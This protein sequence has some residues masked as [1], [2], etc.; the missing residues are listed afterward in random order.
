M[1]SILDGCRP[2]YRRIHWTF[3]E[4]V[5]SFLKSPKTPLFDIDACSKTTNLFFKCCAPSFESYRLGHKIW[6]Y[7]ELVTV[8]EI[9]FCLFNVSNNCKPYNLDAHHSAQRYV[10]R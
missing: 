10:H 3:C 2:I 5:G 8:Y 6:L 1:N 4:G 7:L 9:S